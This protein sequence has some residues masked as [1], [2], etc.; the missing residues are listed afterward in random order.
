MAHRWRGLATDAPTNSRRSGAGAR[1]DRSFGFAEI[2]RWSSWQHGSAIM[3]RHLG[4]CSID[5]RLV[6]AGLDDGDLGVVG[7]NQTRHSANGREGTR[8]GSD[9][10]DECLRPGSFHVGEI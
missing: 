2:L 4:V 9:P 5:L 3:R 10:I 7:N 6:K 1:T 8:M